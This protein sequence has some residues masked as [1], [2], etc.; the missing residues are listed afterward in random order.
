VQRVNWSLLDDPTLFQPVR[1]SPAAA[2]AGITPDNVG[3]R[4]FLR[5]ERQTLSALPASAAV[6]FT[7][8]VHVYP[9]ARI[10]ARPDLAAQLAEAVRALPAEI[11][12]YKRLGGF[13]AALLAYL[14]AEA[15][16]AEGSLA[17]A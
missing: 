5:S 14:D 13:E 6:L 7:I 16:R 10:A 3:Q 15:A 8:H 9:L 17:V 12:A 11:R 4:V 2:D 1:L